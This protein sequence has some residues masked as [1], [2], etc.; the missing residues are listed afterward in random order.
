MGLT[1]L[2]DANPFILGT[3]DRILNLT[4]G[5]SS[6]TDADNNHRPGVDPS[7]TCSFVN[8]PEFRNV[9]K[10]SYNSLQVSLTRQLSDTA[11]LGTYLFHGCLYLGA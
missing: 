10:A 7:A 11:W 4:P 9:G 3:T 8:M 5:N 1:G 6:C 2:Q